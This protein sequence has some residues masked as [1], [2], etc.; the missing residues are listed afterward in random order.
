MSTRRRLLAAALT[1]LGLAAPAVAQLPPP[2][3]AHVT[4]LWG[5]DRDGGRYAR[6][7]VWV[8]QWVDPGGAAWVWNAFY[9]LQDLRQKEARYGGRPLEWRVWGATPLPGSGSPDV[10]FM[11]TNHVN[12]AMALDAR[13]LWENVPDDW[14]DTHTF[15]PIGH[16]SMEV[17][18]LWWDEA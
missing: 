12:F 3:D 4:Q 8:Y 7:V 2:P 6:A 10:P 11:S 14:F 5:I 13:G 15:V 18:I 17:D 1:G 9:V 16:A